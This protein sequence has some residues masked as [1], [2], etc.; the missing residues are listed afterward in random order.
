MLFVFIQEYWCKRRF[1]YRM[2]FESFISNTS[3]SYLPLPAPEFTPFFVGSCCLIVGFC[4]CFVDLLLSFLELPLLIITLASSNFSLNRHHI[5]LCN[6]KQKEKDENKTKRHWHVNIFCKFQFF[7]NCIMNQRYG[8]ELWCLTPLSKNN[9][10]ASYC[11][12]TMYFAVEFN[13]LG[14]RPLASLIKTHYTS[15]TYGCHHFANHG[16]YPFKCSW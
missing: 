16:F 10:V 7:Y 3:R 14:K 11:L 6:I 5:Y 12:S 13:I 8:F 1:P 4:L 15:Y 2:M 9:V